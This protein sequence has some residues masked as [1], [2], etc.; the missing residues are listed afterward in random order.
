MQV[1]AVLLPILIAVPPVMGFIFESG[2]LD[3]FKKCRTIADNGVPTPCGR[4]GIGLRARAVQL[5]ER[6][7]SVKHTAVREDNEDEA[8]TATGDRMSVTRVVVSQ[9]DD[10]P[11]TASD[12]PASAPL[13]NEG[14]K[15]VA[16]ESDALKSMALAFQHLDVNEDG[17]LDYREL[18]NGLNLL[19]AV[20]TTYTAAAALLKRYDMDLDARMSLDE[21]VQLI[22]DL[23]AGMVRSDL[24]VIP[25][26]VSSFAF[27]LDS[28]KGFFSPT[29]SEGTAPQQSTRQYATDAFTA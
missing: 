10:A 4:I 12:S 18:R 22:S 15:A 17:R 1:M 6:L 3:E 20:D 14:S 11:T 21:F 8:T 23:N 13:D 28:I 25:A 2:F 19:A 27:T 16:M 7:L 29:R 26:D 9:C 24:T 5:L